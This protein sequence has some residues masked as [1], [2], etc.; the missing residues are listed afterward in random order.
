MT[1]LATAVAIILIIEGGLYALF[2]DAMKRMMRVALEQPADTLRTAGMVAA[3][4]GVALLWL[5]RG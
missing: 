5:L 1:E 2:P 3:F 4:A